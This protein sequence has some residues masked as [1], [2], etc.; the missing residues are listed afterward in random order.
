MAQR[1]KQRPPGSNW[2]EFG[3][4]DQRGRIELRDAR[5]GAAGRR[6]GEG[7]HQLLPV[8][9]ARLSRRQ[10]SLNP[11]RNPPRLAA[12]RAQRQ[13]ELLLIRSAAMTRP[14][15]R[16]LRRPGAADAAVLDA[17]GQLRPHRQPFD[18]DGDGRR[19][20]RVLQ[21][22]PRRPDIVGPAK[23]GTRK[24]SGAVG[25]HPARRRVGIENMA[26]H[27]VQGRGV[28][29]DLRRAFRPR[30]AA[31][32]LRRA[33]ERAWR[34]TA[35]RSRRATWCACTP[36]SPTSS[37]TWAASPTTSCCTRPGAALDGRDERLLQWIADIGPG[38]ADR[39]TTRG[40]RASRRGP[41]GRPRRLDAAARAL[42]V[43]A[44]HPPRRDVV[45]DELARWLRGT[46]PQPLSADRAAAA[47]A[48]RG[49][50]ARDAGG[51]P[52]EGRSH[53]RR[54]LGHG[55]GDGARAGQARLAG[56]DGCSRRT[57][58]RPSRVTGDING[59]ALQGDVAQDAD[60]RRVAR[61]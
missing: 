46:Q 56:R 31:G 21:R 33:D 7:G 20:D 15:R 19:R 23:A 58:R 11:R 43:Q 4:D 38:G 37:S 40:R 42:P 41:R 51:A 50:L 12:D 45:S 55:R 18:A 30:R 53:Y 48:R 5:K 27:G 22:L 25:G 16:G 54:L 10:Q 8:A 34:T 9:A 47:P 29:I 57:R 49:R 52:S 61:R 1:W 36:A 24:A 6:G 26:E 3:P 59:L 28:M 13:A 17:V 2:G 14:D 35:S 39:A 32:R 44:R 60:C